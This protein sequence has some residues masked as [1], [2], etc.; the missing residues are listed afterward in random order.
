MRLRPDLLDRNSPEQI[1][2]VQLT[3]DPDMPACHVYME[4]QIFTPD[5]KRFVLH[6]GRGRDDPSHQYLLCDLEDGCS[7]HP[8]TEE[9]GSTAPSVSP[10]G[11]YL[12]YLVDRTEL[13]GGQLS[14]K[15]VKMDGSERETLLVLDRGIPGTSYFPNRIYPLSTIS[16]DGQRLA[17]S[18][19]LGDGHTE[20]AP[21]GLLIFDLTNPGVQ[22]IMEG[23]SWINAHPQYCR[24]RDA[25]EAHDILIQENHGNTHDVRGRM[26]KIFDPELGGDIH[27]IRDDG[28]NLR[29][30]PWGRDGLEFRQGHQCWRGRSAWAITSTYGVDGRRLIESLPVP[31]AGHIGL[32]SPGGIRN[33]LSRNFPEPSFCHF[34]CD[35]QG[36]YLISDAYGGEHVPTDGGRVFL[37]RLGEPGRDAAVAWTYLLNPRSSWRADAHV[38][39]FLSPDA[40]MGFF[41]S[42]EC[43]TLQ[44][45]MVTGL[46]DL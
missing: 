24:S 11:R 38:H 12:Y 20:D 18:A 21:Y 46:G 45:Y 36:Q 17:A 33:D 14:L 1:A 39:P 4:A 31:H 6:R 2:V 30:L 43:G 26:T 35:A 5:S 16:S 40:T 27:V 42:D 9:L 32:R 37:A 7:L 22:L 3:A 28:T 23:P 41:N 25:E 19:F 29:D 15:R 44:A 13:G 10:D 8:I 34:A